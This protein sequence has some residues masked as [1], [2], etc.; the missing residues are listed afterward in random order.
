LDIHKKS[1]SACIRVRVHSHKVE[2]FTAVFGTFTQEL[3]RLGSWLKEHKV[4]Q[5]AMES[6]GVYWIPVWNVL[7]LSRWRFQSLLPGQ[8]ATGAC[9]AGCAAVSSL[10]GPFANCGISRGAG[11][12]CKRTAIGSSTA[13]ATAGVKHAMVNEVPARLTASVGG[14]ID[15]PVGRFVV[16]AFSKE[17]RI[18][19]WRQLMKR[20]LAVVRLFASR[21]RQETGYRLEARIAP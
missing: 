18:V 19:V 5:V 3:E 14:L 1:I 2:T 17:R 10:P 20:A 9:T 21:A 16:G 13:E 8:S 6:T 15:G 12:T 11:F 4:K 7:E